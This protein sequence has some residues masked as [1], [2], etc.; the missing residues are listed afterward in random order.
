M[1]DA[2]QTT[3]SNEIKI[4]LAKLGMVAGLLVATFSLIGAWVVLPYRVAAA[5]A[6]IAR[7]Q[8]EQQKMNEVLIRIDENVKSL[9]E[10]RITR[11]KNSAPN[12]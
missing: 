2:T 1:S 6:A 9:K 10:G 7:V 3:L 4:D 5:E 12:N 11:E 8:A